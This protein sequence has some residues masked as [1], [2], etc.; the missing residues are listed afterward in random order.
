MIDV[1]SEAGGRERRQRELGGDLDIGK[2]HDAEAERVATAGFGAIESA[3]GLAEARELAFWMIEREPGVEPYDSTWRWYLALGLIADN[4]PS[5]DYVREHVP[6]RVLRAIK[7]AFGPGSDKAQKQLRA[8]VESGPMSAEDQNILAW[9]PIR[10]I[11]E[12]PGFAMPLAS[13]S[14]ALARFALG[15]WSR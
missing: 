6:N 2:W 4:R 11:R 9:T 5:V 13:S 14:C 15:P 3:F 12:C 1:S 8:L 7:A 10:S